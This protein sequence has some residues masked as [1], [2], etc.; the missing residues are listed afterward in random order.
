MT[1]AAGSR[2]ATRWRRT[3]LGVV[4]A[5]F[6]GIF[7]VSFVNPF[8]PLFL[9]EDLGVHDP[10]ELAVWTGLILSSASVT[11]LLAGPLWG[12]V[13]DRH[14]RK[15]MLVRAQA[16]AGVMIAIM[17]FS[18][19][20]LQL[21]TLRLLMGLASGVSS[22]SMALVVSETPRARVGWAVGM[23]SSAQAVAVSASPLAAGLLATFLPL[24]VVF[25]C[26]GVLMAATTLPVLALVRE[27]APTGGQRPKASVRQTLRDMDRASRTAILA[28]LAAQT[29]TYVAYLGGQQLVLLRVIGLSNGSGF[30]IGV[31][32]AAMGLATG[33]AASLYHRLVPRLGFRRLAVSGALLMGTSLIAAAL[34]TTTTTV[35][36]S[37]AVAGLSFGVCGPAVQSMLGLEAPRE[38]RATLFGA[39]GSAASLGQV[40]GPIGCGLLAAAIGVEPT[41]AFVVAAALGLGTTLWWRARE[42]S[43]SAEASVT[44]G[45]TS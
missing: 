16:T 23:T 42:P 30:A 25:L 6:A 39:L 38:I 28:L 14:G 2:D 27:S 24:R 33:L 9:V 34:S 45:V 3:L 41:F 32:F 22:A 19:S 1:E 10:R 40:V 35:S 31:A 43:I 18:Q 15:K 17:A 20:P 37:A 7:G 11:K 13:A 26:G 12:V 4:I 44:S 36:I 29:L 21:L 8:A 5:L